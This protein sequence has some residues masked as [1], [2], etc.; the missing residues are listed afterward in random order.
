[1]AAVQ[2]HMTK[3]IDTDTAQGF[4]DKKS[5]QSLQE[6]TASDLVSQALASGD[7]NSVREGLRKNNLEVPVQNALR[8]MQICLRKVRGSES[9]RDTL[10]YKFR[11]L[12]IWSGCSS[13]FFTL[14]PH[15]IRS[16]LTLSLLQNDFTFEK[17]FSYW[18][19]VTRKL[20]SIHPPFSKQMPVACMD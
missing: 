12:R 4:F 20:R 14:N 3:F 18:I 13:L 7:V 6:L 17:K 8:H 1:M 15:D 10:I 2:A 9:E 5:M 16:P 11:A 19:S